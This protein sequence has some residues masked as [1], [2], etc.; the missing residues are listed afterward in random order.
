MKPVRR[1]VLPRCVCRWHMYEAAECA[2]HF[3]NL[4]VNEDDPD[5]RASLR[6]LQDEWLAQV[7][8]WQSEH[9]S[10]RRHAYLPGIETVVRD[11]DGH[12]QRLGELDLIGR[13][14]PR[15]GFLVRGPW[16]PL[17]SGS[18]A[19]AERSEARAGDRDLYVLVTRKVSAK[20]GTAAHRSTGYGR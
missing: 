19:E 11:S 1:V 14:E 7:K 5:R 6:R 8:F 20:N 4:M 16:S 10:E 3:T 18:P 2:N 12:W 13:P 15:F 17:R 9:L